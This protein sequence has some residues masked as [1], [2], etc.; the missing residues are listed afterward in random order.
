MAMIKVSSPSS[1]PLVT[2]AS[3]ALCQRFLSPTHPIRSTNGKPPF[4]RICATITIHPHLPFSLTRRISICNNTNCISPIIHANN[5][6]AV[7]TPLQN[8]RVRMGLR[9]E[10]GD[11]F[12]G[13]VVGS[14]SSSSQKN[15]RDG[16]KAATN[17][18][19]NNKRWTSSECG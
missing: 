13:I 11:R 4:P 15:L 8:F 18:Q 10:V 1:Q 17:K 9:R 3:F 7:I 5:A 16:K 19:T 6:T 2:C 14:S 12:D